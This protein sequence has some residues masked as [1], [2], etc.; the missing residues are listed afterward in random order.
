M[1]HTSMT[2]LALMLAGGAQAATLDFDAASLA[3]LKHGS[4]PS[5]LSLDNVYYGQSYTEEGFQL[6]S[7]LPPGPFAGAHTLYVPDASNLRDIAAASSFAMA[8]SAGA[9][10]TL[11][12]IGG[13]AFSLLSI[14]LAELLRVGGTSR[15][16]TFTGVKADGS[17]S[18]SESFT[19][20]AN[21][22]TFAF[23]SSF[24]NLSSVRWTQSSNATRSLQF[25][26]IKVSAVPEPAVCAMLMAGLGLLALAY[27]QSLRAPAV[28][29]WVR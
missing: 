26:N 1:P 19:F 17:P 21:W 29:R 20:T 5:P 13:G 22:Q 10:A 24:A 8:A 14:D 25:D 15:S 7:S 3:Q 16:I 28:S 6:R 4:V 12:K 9:T 2:V 27:A 18:V 11:S 23:N